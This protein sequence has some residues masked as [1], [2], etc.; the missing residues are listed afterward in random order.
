MGLRPFRPASAQ[1]A[2][3]KHYINLSCFCNEFPALPLCS[4]VSPVVQKTV[5]RGQ[6]ER[7]GVARRSGT[8]S[9]LRLRSVW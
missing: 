1:P 3:Q 2:D 9:F 7:S 6:E 4:S 5:R 8:H